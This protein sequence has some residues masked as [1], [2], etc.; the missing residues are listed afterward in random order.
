M[1]KT[2]RMERGVWYAIEAYEARRG[3]KGRKGGGGGRSKLKRMNKTSICW[4]PLGY[5]SDGKGVAKIPVNMKERRGTR[6]RMVRMGSRDPER[7]WEGRAEAKGGGR[8]EWVSEKG[9]YRAHGMNG[10][11]GNDGGG[12]EEGYM[13]AWLLNTKTKTTHLHAPP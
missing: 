13:H 11:M 6:E 3:G 5:Q 12:K 7:R 4:T 9:K 1:R 2:E 8:K 10:S